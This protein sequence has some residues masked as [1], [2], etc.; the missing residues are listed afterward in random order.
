[1]WRKLLG[2]C[3][4]KCKQIQAVNRTLF[5]VDYYFKNRCTICIFASICRWLRATNSCHDLRPQLFHRGWGL[6]QV[7]ECRQERTPGNPFGR[8]I[9]NT[10]HWKKQSD[11]VLERAFLSNIGVVVFL[12]VHVSFLGRDLGSCCLGIIPGP[13]DPQGKD[14]IKKEQ[15][16]QKKELLR[17]PV[18]AFTMVCWNIPRIGSENL[19]ESPVLTGHN[20]YLPYI[21]LSPMKHYLYTSL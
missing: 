15:E 4:G 21:S 12:D 9:G 11:E 2:D 20:Y 13:L 5:S 1:M 6:P 8:I 7:E 3:G 16:R 19:Q 17:G 14:D 18:I 10:P